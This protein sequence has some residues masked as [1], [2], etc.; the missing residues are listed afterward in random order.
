MGETGSALERADIFIWVG[1]E[2]LQIWDRRREVEKGIPFLLKRDQKIPY[3]PKFHC[4]WE[5][6]DHYSQEL[7]KAVGRGKLRVLLAVPEDATYI[8]TT[9]LVEFVAQAFGRQ[10]KKRRGLVS[11]SQSVSLGKPDEHFIAITRTCRCYCVARVKDGKIADS[12]LLDA[13][14]G[15]RN[16]NTVEFAVRDF[17]AAAASMPVY[18]PESDEDWALMSAGKNVPFSRIATMD[19]KKKR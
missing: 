2:A 15:G 18:Y 1:M 14:G 7:R 16:A 17:S 8:E 4:L 5:D 13:H 9:A 6:P 10:L 3:V 19:K 12:Q 11:C